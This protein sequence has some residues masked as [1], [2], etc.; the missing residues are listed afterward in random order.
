MRT[1]IWLDAPDKMAFLADT[2]PWVEPSDVAA[3]MTQ[4]VSASSI[5]VLED[6]SP[7]S[8]STAMK[9]IKI[10]GGMIIEIAKQLRVVE[11][12]MD[13]GPMGREG[14][15]VSKL[16]EAYGQVIATLKEGGWGK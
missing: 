5:S 4:L 7:E 13:A 12:F 6:P 8:K 3:V 16:P 9:E 10:E 14:N 2:D 1:P 15:T 11:Q